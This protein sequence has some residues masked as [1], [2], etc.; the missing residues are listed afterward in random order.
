[1]RKLKLH[2]ENKDYTLQMNRL[3]LCQVFRHEKV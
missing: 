1:M 2:I 3:D